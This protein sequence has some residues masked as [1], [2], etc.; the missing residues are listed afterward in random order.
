ML[1]ENITNISIRDTN[2]CEKVDMQG[3]DF[4]KL[5]AIS[6][7]PF[8][9]I[10]RHVHNK[11]FQVNERAM[12]LECG[13]LCHQCFACYRALSIWDRGI[14]EDKIKL[15]KIAENYLTKLFMEVIPDITP[16]QALQ[17]VTECNI[18][19][20]KCTTK[21][22]K[23]TVFSNFLIDNST[24]YED[25]DDKKRTVVNIKDSLLQYC[26]QF[27]DLVQTEPVWI[28]DEEN[29]DSKIGIEIGFD[30]I[31]T[32]TYEAN[33]MENTQDIR[34]IGKVDGIHKRLS[35]NSLIIH[36]NKTTSRIDESWVGQWY[37]SHQITG[38]CIF[39]QYFTGQ[40]C[41]QARVLGMQIPQPKYSG[42]GYRTER[43]DRSDTYFADW[44][45]WVLTVY[46]II[47]EYKN[48]PEIAPMNTHNCCKYYRQCNF[49]PL[50][51]QSVEERVET[52]NNEMV[53]DEWSPLDE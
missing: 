52:I 45:R 36:E 7:C 4:S 38:Y 48:N 26:S 10:L 28:E 46:N 22:A 43:V 37:K 49:L 16:E 25:P 44:A 9:G 32:F 3:F 51:V 17:F 11:T 47:E 27:L 50:C 42:T 5:N 41:N 8:Y 29:I 24:Y 34:F 19:A 23:Y 14:E 31:I 6:A 18:E 39:A 53:Y 40:N 20:S 35:D 15:V 1:I 33:G 12:A 30:T 2:E 13:A 21:L